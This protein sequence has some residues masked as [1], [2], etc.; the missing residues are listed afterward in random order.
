MNFLVFNVNGC[1]FVC[2]YSVGVCDCACALQYTFTSKLEI[3]T[4][5]E[6]SSCMHGFPAI[7]LIV[8][9]RLSIIMISL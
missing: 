7:L 4:S 3:N 5:N 2:L 1:M 6:E 8:L 9:S